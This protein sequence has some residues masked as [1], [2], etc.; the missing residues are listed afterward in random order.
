[1]AAELPIELD[2]HRLADGEVVVFHDPELSRMTGVSGAIG[3]Q[4][5]EDLAALRLGGTE[6]RVPL[7]R[8]V[9]DLVDGRVPLVID[10]KNEHEVGAL[11]RAVVLALRDYTGAVALQSFNPSSLAWFRRHAPEYLRG[12]LASDFRRVQLAVHEKF[13]LRRLLLAFV[14]DPDYI[15]YELRCLPY[16]APS[17]ARRLGLPLVAW[18]VRTPEDLARATALA[19]NIIFETIRP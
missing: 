19:D 2:V 5:V 9:L 10:V 16:W 15:G 17:L 14:A 8:D 1:M 13:V 4:R 3:H 12:L 6:A 11:E 7:L 18:T